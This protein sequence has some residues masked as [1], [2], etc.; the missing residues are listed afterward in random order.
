MALI[1][2]GLGIA[3][4]VGISV[5]VDVSVGGSKGSGEAVEEGTT[6]GVV[7]EALAPHEDRVNV[8]ISAH[9]R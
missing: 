9:E 4:A 5:G 2:S 3:V 1:S 7:E 6:A 8:S